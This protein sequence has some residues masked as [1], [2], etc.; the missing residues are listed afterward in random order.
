MTPRS[1]LVAS[2]T[3]EVLRRNCCHLRST[4]ESF[5]L[6]V[7]SNEVPEDIPVVDSHSEE[8][9]TSSSST[10]LT[11]LVFPLPLLVKQTLLLLQFLLLC[12]DQLG[13]LKLQKD[14]TYDFMY[15]LVFFL[16][17]QLEQFHIGNASS[18]FFT[19]GGCSTID[20][21]AVFHYS[22]GHHLCKFIHIRNLVTRTHSCSKSTFVVTLCVLIEPTVGPGQSVCKL[23]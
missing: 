13:E 23:L 2:S 11:V 15:C 7:P 14:W 22:P 6:P 8:L 16:Y 19:R 21:S 4:D 1:Y 5:E 10:S 17:E 20:W 9:I 12:A 18:I 3:G